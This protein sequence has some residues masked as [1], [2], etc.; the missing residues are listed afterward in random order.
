MMITQ[1]SDVAKLPDDAPE[2]YHIVIFNCA[3][4][5]TGQSVVHLF[6]WKDSKWQ[7]HLSIVKVRHKLGLSQIN[8]FFPSVIKFDFD[9]TYEDF[10]CYR[11]FVRHTM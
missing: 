8:W 3:V 2:G 4:C 6:Y 5:L 1:D 11:L 7:R 9:C 10:A